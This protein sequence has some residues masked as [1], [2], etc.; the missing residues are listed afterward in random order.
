[1]TG[2]NGRLTRLEELMTGEQP[3]APPAPR[4]TLKRI[5]TV[6]ERVFR[7]LTPR[8]KAHAQSIFRLGEEKTEEEAREMVGHIWLAR[9]LKGSGR[10]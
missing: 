1:M 10:R 8:V 4:E 6:L 3:P 9:K 7:E 5:E 2:L